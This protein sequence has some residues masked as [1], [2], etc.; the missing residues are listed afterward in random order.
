MK[1]A[2]GYYGQVVEKDENI[3]KMLGQ[4]R[5]KSETFQL[6]IDEV[7]HF[8]DENI[9]DTQSVIK[10]TFEKYY[11][12]AN[13][14]MSLVLRAGI[15]RGTKATFDLIRESVAKINKSF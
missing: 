1:D 3:K 11:K 7:K 13:A 5:G 8:L 14:A 6:D 12:P 4:F 2:I 10:C 9:P 15:E